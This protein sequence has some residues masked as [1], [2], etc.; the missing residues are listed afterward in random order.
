MI[1]ISRVTPNMKTEMLKFNLTYW[2]FKC[3]CFLSIHVVNEY[4]SR[5]LQLLKLNDVNQTIHL[6]MKQI[7]KKYL[8]SLSQTQI[9]YDCNLGPDLLTSP[10]CT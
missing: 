5:S 1:K 3:F 9:K 4:G 6:N 2:F 10:M 7:L 8:L